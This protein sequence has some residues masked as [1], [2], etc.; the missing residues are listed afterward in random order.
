MKKVLLATTLSLCINSAFAAETAVL[1]V[2]G[3]LTNA[4]CTP[5]LSNG[6]VVD[7]G[8]IHLAELSANEIN[9]LGHKNIDLTINCTAATKVAWNL[10]D[11]RV[12]SRAN[13]TVKN[14]SYYNDTVV[15]GNHSQLYG[16][17]KT[18][19]GVNIGNYA[20]FV[21]LDSVTADGNSVDTIY[22]QTGATV[23]YKSGSTTQGDSYRNITVAE[24]G[25]LEP[26]SFLTATFPLTTSLAIQDTT[27]LAITDDTEMDGQLTI[28]LKY[29]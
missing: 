28:S 19:D 15:G 12:D 11:D 17:G 3:M 23:W 10:V 1:K 5:E 4:A 8:V 25:S 7:Y 13:I 2:K 21:N 29:I 18:A 22:L 24:T 27:T 16:V 9:Q 26:L 6:G 14:G 20:M